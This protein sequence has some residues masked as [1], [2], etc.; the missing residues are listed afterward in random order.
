MK[1]LVFVLLIFVTSINAQKTDSTTIQSLK[2]FESNHNLKTKGSTI[3]Y[4]VNA[5][6]MFLR[7]AKQKPTAKIW[8]TSYIVGS[9]SPRPVAFVFNGGPGSA[10]LWLHMG[11]LGPKIVRTASDADQDDGAAPYQ[12]IDNPNCLLDKMD[13]VFIDPVGTGYSHVVGKGKVEKYWGLMEDARSIADFIRTWITK[14]NRWNS[15]KYLIG[16]SFGTTRSAAVSDI[17]LGGGQSVALNGIVMISQAMDYAGSTSEHH[18][19]T[20]FLTYLPSMSATAWYHKKAGVG[21]SLESF[22]QE[23]REYA[24]DTYAPALLKGSLLGEDEKSSVAN[25]LSY[26]MGLDEDYIL[27]SNLRVLMPRFQKELLRSEGKTIG[28]L[29]GRY[30]QEEYD[31]VADRPTLGDAASNSISSAYTSAL[32]SYFAED[33]KIEMDRPY[34]TSNRAIYPKWNWKPVSASS[35]WE[36]K[37]VNTAPMLGRAMRKNADL[38][39]LVASGYYDLITPFFDAEYTVSR[40]GIIQER[41]EFTYYEAGHMMYT[42]HQAFDQL[43]SDIRDFIDR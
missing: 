13:L 4:Q 3:N 16:E 6:E 24:F 43:C 15:P 21:K 17:L 5:G 19:I 38:N 11:L 27:K 28:R 8:S 35:G 42:L 31:Q 22:V 20:S 1:L 12:I 33:L 2:S 34:L 39:V 7:D 32:Q 9:N 25:R 10:S 14:H 23:S 41:V 18:N 37:Y 40:N 26:F 30:M 36:P 29:D